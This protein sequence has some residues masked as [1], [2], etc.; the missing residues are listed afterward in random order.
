MARLLDR[1]TLV[2][3]LRM[4][5]AALA[6]FGVAAAFGFAQPFWAVI[7]ALIVVQSNVGGSLKAALDRF[8]GSVCGALYGGLVAML[9]PHP[10]DAGRALALFLAI[11]PLSLL[12]ARSAG[13][14]V[15]PI[16]AVIVLL[17]AT[18]AALGPLGFALERVLEVGLG[19][20]VALLAAL[21]IVPARASLGALA[22]AGQ[23][24]R[25]LG[26]QLAALARSDEH[27]APDVAPLVAETIKSLTAL[28]TLVGEA[29]RERSSLLSRAP[30]PAPLLR[31]L[32]RLRHDVAML[33]RAEVGVLH[34]MSDGQLAGPWAEVVTTAA[35]SLDTLGVALGDG[36]VPGPDTRLATA[37]E[38]YEAV[39]EQVREK[40]L[41]R[42]LTVDEV[43]QFFGIGFTLD[44]LRRDLDDLRQRA[45]EIARGG[46]KAD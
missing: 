43:G 35:A 19:C 30:D 22:A 44:Q 33:R 36:R 14:R 34:R 16:T 9:V 42:V 37:L 29:A 20:V 10:T 41:T 18:G 45:E 39:V 46:H 13:F 21:L 3:A 25:L 31:T 12:A 28:E 2:Q 15:A 4:T 5:A 38:A 40:G 26:R 7:T 32:T 17:G 6:A 24:A 8:V 23:G 27:G 11:A 1:P